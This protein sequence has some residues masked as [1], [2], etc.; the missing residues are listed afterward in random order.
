MFL[1][2]RLGQAT[3][4]YIL[5]FGFMAM[6]AVSMA[7]ALTGTMQSSVGGLALAMTNY[8]TT[9]VCK[10]LCFYAGYKNGAK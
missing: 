2:N 4:E 1:K 10:E 3:I 9:G 8:L 5:L 7:R 6:I